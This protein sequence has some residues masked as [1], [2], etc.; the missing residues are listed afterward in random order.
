MLKEFLV[1]SLKEPREGCIRYLLD[2]HIPL[3]NT[4]PAARESSLGL[5]VAC[6][7]RTEDC[8]NVTCAYERESGPMMLAEHVVKSFMM[9]AA[10]ES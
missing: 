8:A 10:K 1:S 5:S 6:V 3:S 9:A 2:H 4:V 7:L